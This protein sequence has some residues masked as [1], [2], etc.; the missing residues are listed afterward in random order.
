[1]L[2][3]LSVEVGFYDTQTDPAAGPAL[4]GNMTF[5][6]SHALTY[7]YINQTAWGRMWSDSLAVHPNNLQQPRASK[8]TPGYVDTPNAVAV[9]RETKESGGG[10]VAL[11]VGEVAQ[12][13]R[14]R[15]PHRLIRQKL[16]LASL[17]DY[18]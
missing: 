4:L 10:S 13:D 11:P 9:L 6:T 17:A 12:Q 5:V 1:M 8:S 15:R 14:D 2:H 16:A 18:F 7:L 3:S